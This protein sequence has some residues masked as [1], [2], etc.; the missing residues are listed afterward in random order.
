MR[1][2]IDSA[3]MPGSNTPKPPGSQIHACPGCQWRTSSFHVTSRRRICLRA[4]CLRASSTPALNGDCQVA[5]TAWRALALAGYNL[6]DPAVARAALGRLLRADPRSLADTTLWPL[7]LRATVAWP[8]VRH[9][10]LAR[11]RAAERS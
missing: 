6:G 8:L 1:V 9:R 11:R 7:L 3:L 5:K 10:R 2:T 4:S